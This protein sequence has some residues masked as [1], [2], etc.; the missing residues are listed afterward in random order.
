MLGWVPPGL[1]YYDAVG[2]RLDP[3]PTPA[4]STS[5][6]AAATAASPDDPATTAT[7]ASGT[8]SQRE[9]HCGDPALFVE[10]DQLIR[11]TKRVDESQWEG[12][13]RPYLRGD[14]DYLL[15]WVDQHVAPRLPGV[16]VRARLLQGVLVEVVDLHHPLAAGLVPQEQ[17]QQLEAETQRVV[18]VVLGPLPPLP[19]PGQQQGGRGGGRGRGRK[20]GRG[21]RG[22][23]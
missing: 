16:C 21:G 22:R 23:S 15:G 20:G 1:V 18:E 14:L 2:T 11:G 9:G 13:E 6:P 19:S 17:M 5:D 8:G 3:T 4:T 12:G 10:L 7:T